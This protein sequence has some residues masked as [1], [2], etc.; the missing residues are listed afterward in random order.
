MTLLPLLAPAARGAAR[1]RALHGHSNEEAQRCHGQGHVLEAEQ[2]L[3][4][5]TISRP[6]HD[7]QRKR[8]LDQAFGPTKRYLVSL[9][10][11][12]PSRSYY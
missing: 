8:R 12:S 3:Q 11:K 1:E 10:A 2:V 5:A 6:E 9:H 7:S 4:D